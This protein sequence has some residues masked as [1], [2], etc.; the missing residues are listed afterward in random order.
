M[1]GTLAPT[2]PPGGIAGTGIALVEVSAHRRSGDAGEEAPP[3]PP[4]TFEAY[5]KKSEDNA[6]VVAMVDLLIKDLDKEMTEAKTAEAD[7]QADYEA[8]MADSAEK[9]AQ[10]SQS[11]TEKEAALAD[12]EAVLEEHKDA[13]A[14]G[15]KELM[16]V[17]GYI[18]TLHAD[19]D[20]LMKYYEVRK[21]AR[22]EE[23][24]GLDKAK[25]VLSG[26]DYSLVQKTRRV[27]T[28]LGR[29]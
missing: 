17:E 6:G 7:A 18:A 28:F 21:T 1:G 11:L 15:V 25:A 14:A 19:C 29:K 9:R 8:M 3:P 24:D 13:K 5:A 20:W 16:A 23:I 22:T 10:D 27:R 26:A 2:Q 4:E 12:T